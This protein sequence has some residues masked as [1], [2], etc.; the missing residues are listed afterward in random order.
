MCVYVC[1]VC[2]VVYIYY[3]HANSCPFLAPVPQSCN[4]MYA[5]NA[6]IVC[7]VPPGTGKSYYLN[8]TASPNLHRQ[9]V[10][11]NTATFNYAS[12]S[13]SSIWYYNYVPTTGGFITIVGANFGNDTSQVYTHLPGSSNSPHGLH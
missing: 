9:N 10:L 2:V 6:F 13:I 3:L 12:P 8:V 4:V 11:G 1:V 5:T 7:K